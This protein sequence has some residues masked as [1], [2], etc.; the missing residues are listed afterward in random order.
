MPA[1]I[2]A[3]PNFQIISGS[4][5]DPVGTILSGSSTR[6]KT[7]GTYT[8]IVST[9]NSTTTPLASGSVFTGVGEE[10][11]DYATIVVQVFADQASITD[12]LNP[13][14]SPDGTNWDN[15]HSKFNVNANSGRAFS[16]PPRA[17][18][19]RIVYTNGSVAQTEFRLQTIYHYTRTKP[20]STPIENDV[21]STDD[22][23][24]IKSIITGRTS[25]GSYKNVSVDEQGQLHVVASIGAPAAGVET[26]LI[27]GEV[28]SGGPNVVAVRKT[29][30][31]E[32][33]TGAQRSIASNNANDTAAGTGARTVRI[34]Y[35]DSSLTTKSTEDLTLN[36]TTG[37]NTVATDICFIEKIEVLTVGST[38]EAQGTITLYTGIN[39]TGSTIGTISPGDNQTFW[40]HHYVVSGKTFFLT[41]MT[42]GIK[43]KE[44]GRLFGRTRNPVNADSAPKK[45]TPFLVIAAPTAANALIA[46]F[47]SPI[48]IIEGPAIF[49]LFIDASAAETYYAGFSFVE[50]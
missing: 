14:W 41:T 34:T 13:Q 8:S 50:Q 26:G 1:V 6:L 20:S 21:V 9:G 44:T 24:L 33:T 30:Y 49:T 37:V 10:V 12:G 23:E 43:I 7:D 47:S 5:G 29:A 18:Y 46:N 28:N 25:G 3:N 17:R 11:K 42:G 35:F 38:G 32:Q 16:F 45:S 39:K 27:H 40:A 2:V 36:G 15:V 19:F 22:A 31:N 4:D 48:D